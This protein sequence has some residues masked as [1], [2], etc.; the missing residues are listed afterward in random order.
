MIL[1]YFLLSVL[2]LCAP[3]AAPVR[4]A[5][6]DAAHSAIE[7]QAAGPASSGLS[8]KGQAKNLFTYFSTDAYL[9]T[10]RAKALAADLTRLRLSPELTVSDWLLV[11]VDYDNEI[12]MGGYLKSPEFDMYWR[13]PDYNDLADLSWEP[14]YSKDIYYRHAV[15]RAYAKLV[16]GRLTT[17]VGRQQVRFGSGR[18]WN[19]LDILNPISPTTVEDAGEQKGIDALRLEHYL[20]DT[21][22]AGLIFDG[23]RKN[24]RDGSNAVSP[25]NSNI[26][27]RI[28]TTLG[29]T[30]IAAL[31]G[32][33]ARRATG[34]IDASTIVLDGMLRGSMLYSD[35]ED[36][37]SFI[38]ASAGYEYTFASGLY[39]LMEYFYN[40]NGLNFNDDLRAAYMMSRIAGVNESNYTTLANQFLTYNQHYAGLA[41]GIDITPLIRGELFTIYDFQGRGVFVS[42][43]LR[44]NP[45]ENINLIAGVMA[46]GI[47]P[48]AARSSD[49][50]IFEG[51]SLIFASMAWYF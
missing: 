26:V 47:L 21:T 41:L 17:T 31:G 3:A 16:T 51:H 9:A 13:A 18:L 49:F 19:P 12:I 30:E 33:I 40:Q 7:E 38:L 28:K 46:A 22:E 32:R 39:F 29:K 1:L 5:E 50:E 27:G 2:F 20:T 10:G 42:P 45:F 43:S 8:L 23:K 14:Y 25:D 11:H 37:A 36:G 4:A 35:P 24:N 15:H 6:S 48:G 34:G 44:Y